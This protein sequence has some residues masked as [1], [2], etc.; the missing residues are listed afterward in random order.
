MTHPLCVHSILASV[1][2]SEN[3]RH[4][5]L[6]TLMAKIKRSRESL[7]KKSMFNRR[8]KPKQKGNDQ[9]EEEIRVYIAENKSR[10]SL[11]EFIYSVKNHIQLSLH[12][13]ALGYKVHQG[14]RQTK[15]SV[16]K[17]LSF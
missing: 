12:V 13:C 8:I 2:H 4:S 6:L 3:I 9:R 7:K 16:L 5:Y 14:I 10:E 17:E 1:R 15:I 11:K